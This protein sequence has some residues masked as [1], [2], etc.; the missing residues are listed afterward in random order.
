MPQG[1]ARPSLTGK[2]DEILDYKILYDDHHFFSAVT[3]PVKVFFTIVRDAVYR[4]P[5]ENMDV[6]TYIDPNGNPCWCI[7]CAWAPAH[8]YAR[9]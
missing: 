7:A 9:I 8:A 5:S 4:D 6:V 3:V 2:I 1:Q